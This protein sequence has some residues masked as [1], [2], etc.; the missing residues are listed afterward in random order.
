MKDRSIHQGPDVS[1]KGWLEEPADVRDSGSWKSVSLGLAGQLHF[2]LSPEMERERSTSAKRAPKRSTRSE[3]SSKRSSE[4]IRRSADSYRAPRYTTTSDLIERT[5]HLQLKK[6]VSAKRIYEISVYADTK[7]RDEGSR[8]T[9]IEVS[10]PKST[11]QIRLE[12]W[13]SHSEHFEIVGKDT[14]RIV[15]RKNRKRS[16]SAKFRVA[17]AN[18]H[19][20]YSIFLAAMFRYKGRPCGRVLRYLAASATHNLR[21]VLDGPRR[22]NSDVPAEVALP[23]I[24]RNAAIT[25]EMSAKTPDVRIEVFRSRENDGRHFKMKCFTPKGKWSGP[26]N[27]NEDTRTIVNAHIQEFKTK[28][29]A[30]RIKSLEAAGVDFWKVVPERVQKLLMKS[31]ESSLV[32]SI[33]VTSQEPYIP[34]ELMIPNFAVNRHPL[35]VDFNVGRWVTGDY[36]APKQSLQLRS[37]FIIRPKDSKLRFAD[38][39]ATF[40]KRTFNL[41]AIEVV[42]ATF[43]NVDTTLKT[44]GRDAIHFICH[45]K[46]GPLQTV[47]LDSPDTL[48]C[49]Q[50][51]VMDGFVEAFRKNPLAFLNACEVGSPVPSLIGVGGF[52]TSFIELGAAAVVAP[53][54]A[55]QDSIALDVT[56]MFYGGVQSGIT[57]SEAVRRIREKAYKLAIDSYAAYC[58]YGDPLAHIAREA[59]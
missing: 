3:T 53:L 46:S 41:G 4:H 29:G 52:A 24:G 57:L 18:P 38:D 5:P 6:L 45:G 30:Q 10:V 42:P 49:A 59:P 58:F 17:F 31:I 39:E 26:W 25:V 43:E 55:V 7:P 21:F 9:P 47:R 20:P 44:G 2:S 13:L 32:Q 15:I 36:I 33:L 50:V 1:F 54:W 34:W 35:G 11:T 12:V 8:T 28:T 23:R 48:T 56:S 19:D 40:L 37:V 51:Q 22:E 27:L 14:A 16:D